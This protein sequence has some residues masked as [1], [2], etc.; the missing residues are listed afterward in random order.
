MS[1]NNCYNG[2]T[3]TTSDQCVKYT[4]IDIPALGI[5][6]GDT[7]LSIE[8]SITSFISKIIIGEGVYPIIDNSIICNLVK[9]YLP[10]IGNINLNQ[11]ISAI[12]NS[13]CALQEQIN[14]INASL[15]ILEGDY[16]VTCLEGV[17]ANSGTHSIVQAIIIK[18]CQTDIDLGALALNI[19]TNYVAIADI[20]TYIA[21]YLATFPTSS[22][23]YKNIMIPYVAVPYFGS[24][25]YFDITGK[26][27]GQWDKIYLCNGQ[28]TAVPDLR[29]LTLVGSTA[30]GT[31]PFNSLVDPGI[32]G[33][34]TYNLGSIN[35]SNTITLNSNQI[36]AHTHTPTVTVTDPGHT[37]GYAF[38][39]DYPGGSNTIVLGPSNR[40]TRQTDSSG[41]NG[42]GI[43]VNV[44]VGSNTTTNSYHAN[45]Q[46]GY[47]CYYIIYIP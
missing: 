31:S 12:I 10:D 36:P 20:N 16:T 24:L 42:T 5:S 21:A 1:C 32:P 29:G 45:V 17:S 39:N 43:T 22:N 37:H 44:A 35:G 19:S 7:L 38:G 9:P 28:N 3:E 14:N 18:L 6:H 46:P 4:G 30:M 26:G 41:V 8:N 13:T 2:C 34:P 40:G 27:V 15:T 11:Y 25:S 47:G 23:L 33:N